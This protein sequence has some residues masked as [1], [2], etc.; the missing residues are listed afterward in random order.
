MGCLATAWCLALPFLA[1]DRLALESLTSI[2]YHVRFSP[3]YSLFSLLIELKNS[4][5]QSITRF[6]GSARVDLFPFNVTVSLIFL[7]L[8]GLIDPS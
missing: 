3:L 6:E 8:F 7:L 5:L 2:S 4:D 1:S